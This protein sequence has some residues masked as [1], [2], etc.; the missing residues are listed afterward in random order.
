M[1]RTRVSEISTSPAGFSLPDLRHCDW[2][3][4]CSRSALR[5]GDHL[6]FRAEDALIVRMGARAVRSNGSANISQAAD[7]TGDRSES[8]GARDKMRQLCASALAE[9][10]DVAALAQLAS[11]GAARLV[12]SRGLASRSPPASSVS[13]DETL[14]VLRKRMTEGF[15]RGHVVEFLLVGKIFP[16]GGQ[17]VPRPARVCLVATRALAA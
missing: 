9:G 10:I 13:F 17:L 15:T 16:H 6:V 12:P 14:A 8:A 1:P 11:A 5:L 4:P 2:P 7:R 3:S